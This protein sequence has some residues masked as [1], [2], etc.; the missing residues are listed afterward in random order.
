MK[1]QALKTL[2]ELTDMQKINYKKLV[3]SPQYAALFIYSIYPDIALAINQHAI[4][5]ANSG[6]A[7][8]EASL[9]VLRHPSGTK[10]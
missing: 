8:M 5:L 9:R 4:F 3:G 6:R 2:E 10:T 7:H 1:E